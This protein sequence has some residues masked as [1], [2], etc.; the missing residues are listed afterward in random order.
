MCVVLAHNA[1]DTV[2]DIVI[3]SL[4]QGR[5]YTTASILTRYFRYCTHLSVTPPSG[6]RA[7]RLFTLAEQIKNQTNNIPPPI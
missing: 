2:I 3:S 5:I 7:V 1:A 4:P 6:R